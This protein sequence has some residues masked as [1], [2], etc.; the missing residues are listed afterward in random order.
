MCHSNHLLCPKYVVLL[1]EARV[2]DGQ[3]A[4]LNVGCVMDM[5]LWARF[6]VCPVRKDVSKSGRW[7]ER[8]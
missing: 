1:E 8:R 2:V 6:S 7:G 5:F 4:A 3:S